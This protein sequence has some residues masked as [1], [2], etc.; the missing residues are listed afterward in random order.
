[1]SPLRNTFSLGALLFSK[2]EIFIKIRYY[3]S[4]RFANFELNAESKK[5]KQLPPLNEFIEEPE[6]S[7]PHSDHVSSIMKEVTQR[8]SPHSPEYPQALLEKM[9]RIK[10]EGR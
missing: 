9:R 10:E 8:V 7:S 5:P 2:I 4:I 3:L 6:T 1:M